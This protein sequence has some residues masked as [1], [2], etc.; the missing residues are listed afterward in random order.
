MSAKKNERP[1]AHLEA[2]RFENGKPLVI[3]GLAERYSGTNAGIPAQWQ[4]FIPHIGRVPGQV[5]HAT[6]GIVFN[7]LKSWMS[8]GYLTGIEVAPDTELPANFGHLEIPAH[9]YAVF[10]HQGHVS[11]ISRTMRSIFD[12]WL[13]QSGHEHASDGADFFERYSEK[14]DP[15]TG[16]GGIEIWLPIKPAS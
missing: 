4:R 1:S 6:Y 13:P 10:A 3:A 15:Q 11:T 9:R 14:F 8:F 12:E 16:T 7:S 5:G 2:P